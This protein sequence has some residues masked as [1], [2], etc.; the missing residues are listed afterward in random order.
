M[1]KSRCFPYALIHPIKLTSPYW[2]SEPVFDGV[3]HTGGL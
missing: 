3:S 2:E 1:H